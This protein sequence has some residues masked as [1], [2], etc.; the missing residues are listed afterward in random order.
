VRLLFWLVVLPLAV[1]VAY[2]AVANRDEVTVT[3]LGYVATTPKFVLILGAVFVGLVIGGVA[4]WLGQRHWRKQARHLHRRV[5]H[6][7]GEIETF[8]NRNVPGTQP[9]ATALPPGAG[10]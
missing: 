9:Q 3:F 8:R 4:T 7:E 1:A 2:F 10:R 5:K 6:L